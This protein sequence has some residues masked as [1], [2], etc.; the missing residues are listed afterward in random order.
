MRAM[1]ITAFGDANRLHL[2]EVNRPE[3]DDEEVLIRIACAAVNPV[4]WK[5]RQ[6]VFDQGPRRRECSFPHVL[7]FDAA[8]V[9]ENVGRNVITVAPGDRVVTCSDGPGKWGTYAEFVTVRQDRVG[10]MPGTLG[11]ADAAAYPLA[12]VT[13]WQDLFAPEK[14]ALQPGQTVLIHG[15]AGGLGSYGI[16]FAKAAGLRVATTCGTGNID[17]VK[18]LGADMVIDY[19]TQ[20]IVAAVREW[21]PN[22][23][24][25]VVDAVGPATLPGVLDLIG[26]G[27]RLVSVATLTDDGDIPAL[28]AAAAARGIEK[29]WAIMS[30]E[31]VTPHLTEIASLIDSGAVRPPPIT[32][33]PLEQLPEAHRLVETG[34]VRG[35]V[36]I[37][38]ADLA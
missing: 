28:K 13:I 38:V 21:M 18:S 22:G 1:V 19:H 15:G 37:H 5:E 4:D 16:Q 24:D 10:P 34:H 32:V 14:G 12:G 9:V 17:Y 27:G 7:G 3:P 35:K 29:I 30:F 26:S 6:G 25:V 2:A 31:N 36:V 33:F 23:V 20:N 11:F 8:G